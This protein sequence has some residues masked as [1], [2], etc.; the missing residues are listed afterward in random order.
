[1]KTLKPCVKLISTDFDG[2]LIEPERHQ[3]IEPAF[4]DLLEKS[5][6][7]DQTL[8]II[9]TGRDWESLSQELVERQTPIYPDYVVTVE[10]Q[11]FQI[12]GKEAVSLHEWNRK[13][14]VLHTQLFDAVQPLWKKIE[15]FIR[16]ETEAQ[17]VVDVGCPLGIIAQDEVEAEYI[18][19]HINPW[20][21]SW[22]NLSVV[23]NTI[24]FRFA[25]A[26]YHK[27]SCLQAIARRHRLAP[28]FVFAAGD[29]FNDLSM[30]HPSIAKHMAC[31]VNAIE[32]VKEQ[33]RQHGG[34]VSE[35]RTALG[36]V[37]GWQALTNPPE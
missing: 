9:N 34:F 32:E 16:V 30:L 23:R 2:T 26:A 25:H 10:R 6:R 24:Y 5:R 11:I 4:F 19:A 31:P 36:I 33:V 20:V 22:P 17:L 3:P 14:A 27:G 15:D 18:A 37:E 1:M 12:Q 13:C 7:D 8:W 21:V 35:L 29:H 28:D